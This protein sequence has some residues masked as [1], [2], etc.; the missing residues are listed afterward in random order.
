MGAPAKR[1]ASLDFAALMAKQ[2]KK[3]S[4]QVRQA[5]DEAFKATSGRAQEGRDLAQEVVD[6]LT[7]AA[8]R[9][10]DVLEDMRPPSGDDLRGLRDEVTA[11]RREMQ[12]I[13][14]RLGKLEA[15]PKRATAAKPKPKAT[16]KRTTKRAPRTKP[17]GS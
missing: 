2:Q 11:L 9:L 7:S 13:G 14:E 12:A 15:A 5:V 8:G 16:P 10:R 4:E 1:P 6:E 17:A 3:R